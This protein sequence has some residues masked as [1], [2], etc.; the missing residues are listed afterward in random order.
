MQLNLLDQQISALI[1]LWRYKSSRKVILDFP[2]VGRVL[3]RM[4]PQK[5]ATDPMG[6]NISDTYILLKD[7]KSGKKRMGRRTKNELIRDIKAKLESLIPGQT[8]IFSQPIQLRFNELLEGVRADV[9][10]KVFR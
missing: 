7:K 10:L 8:I 6:P 1:N 2:E 4:E 9:A 3:S 5:F